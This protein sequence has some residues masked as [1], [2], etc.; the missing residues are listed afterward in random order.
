M[1]YSAKFSRLFASENSRLRPILID[2]AIRYVIEI[3][4]KSL[5]LF[6]NDWV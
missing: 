3:L 1:I 2:V 4:K 6:L 5:N